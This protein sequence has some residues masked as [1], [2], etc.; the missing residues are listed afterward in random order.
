MLNRYSVVLVRPIRS[1]VSAH[2]KRSRNWLPFWHRIRQLSAPEATTWLTADC[3]PVSRFSSRG[4]VF[5]DRDQRPV[6]E[7]SAP[8]HL[9]ST[10]SRS[11]FAALQLEQIERASEALAYRFPTR[12]WGSG[13]LL[14]PH[15]PVGLSRSVACFIRIITGRFRLCLECLQLDLCL[16][17][18]AGWTIAR[19]GGSAPSGA[20]QRL[21]VERRFFRGC[22]LSRD[23]LVFR[24][25][26]TSRRERISHVSSE[27]EGP[28]ILVCARREAWQRR[29]PMQRQNSLPPSESRLSDCCCSISA[30]AGALPPR[31]SS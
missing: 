14:R 5:S 28:R 7:R 19:P 2:L 29:S 1:G 17:A 10:A 6:D 4:V 24:S 9:V 15:Q 25:A 13:Q 12:S 8:G 27:C 23:Q 18:D 30:G 20:N 26:T 31:A 21:S 16:G 3:S 22:A 11:A